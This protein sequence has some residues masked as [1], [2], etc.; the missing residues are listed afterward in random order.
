MNCL[1]QTRCSFRLRRILWA[2]NHL[3]TIWDIKRKNKSEKMARC[4]NIPNKILTSNLQPTTGQMSRVPWVPL[5]SHP[6]TT[7]FR[8]SSH[9]TSPVLEQKTS[10]YSWTLTEN[11]SRHPAPMTSVFLRERQPL[12]ITTSITRTEMAAKSRSTLMYSDLSRT[13]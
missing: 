9:K 6:T 2:R 8:R 12:R 1:S 13:Y 7:S 4:R 3:R 10:K 11:P 5:A